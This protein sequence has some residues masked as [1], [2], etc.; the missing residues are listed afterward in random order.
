MDYIENSVD[1][2]DSYVNSA[3]RTLL[4]GI[5]LG[6]QKEF[7]KHA[8]TVPQGAD[9]DSMQNAMEFDRAIVLILERRIKDL[10]TIL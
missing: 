6:V 4:E 3:P 10:I 9:L 2:C 7:Y 1:I 8:W 5:P